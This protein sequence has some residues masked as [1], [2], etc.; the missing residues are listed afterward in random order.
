VDAADVGGWMDV[1]ASGTDTTILPELTALPTDPA[2][3]GVDVITLPDNGLEFTLLT[4]TDSET[5][6]NGM[7]LE[8]LALIPQTPPLSTFSFLEAPSIPPQ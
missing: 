3:L 5:V 7:G 2:A 8:P 4:T 6:D 1:A